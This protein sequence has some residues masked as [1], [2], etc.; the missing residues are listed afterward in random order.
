MGDGNLFSTCLYQFPPHFPLKKNTCSCNNSVQLRQFQDK[1]LSQIVLFFQPWKTFAEKLFP[2]SLSLPSFHWIQSLPSPFSEVDV[3][4][5]FGF[6][7]TQGLR[8]S[9]GNFSQLPTS[10]SLSWIKTLF[11]LSKFEKFRFFFIFYFLLIFFFYFHLLLLNSFIFSQITH[12]LCISFVLYG[13]LLS[14]E[15]IRDGLIKKNPL[16]PPPKKKKM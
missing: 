10:L 1:L 8:I 2:V 5:F 7:E 16:F 15:F 4:L 14:C 12:Y 3:V 11:C 9:F 13:K 6:L